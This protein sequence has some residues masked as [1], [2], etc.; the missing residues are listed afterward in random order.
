MALP[1][2]VADSFLYVCVCLI[3]WRCAAYQQLH[4]WA[5]AIQIYDEVLDY[6]TRY[7]HHTYIHIGSLT[8][9]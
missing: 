1:G 2:P 3:V 4:D 6:N 9:T 8:P 5:S 7:G